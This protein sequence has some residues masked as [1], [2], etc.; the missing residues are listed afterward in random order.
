MS[1]ETKRGDGAEVRL[2]SLLEVRPGDDLCAL[3]LAA[4]QRGEETLRDGHVLVLAQKIVSKAEDRMVL[5][6]TCTRPAC[7]G[8]RCWT[9]SSW[10][11][12]M[13]PP[14]QQFW[15]LESAP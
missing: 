12:Q 15:R 4:L 2:R 9:D 7:T 1:Q 8:T 13:R 5:L 11:T 3:I 14:R 10:T 6:A